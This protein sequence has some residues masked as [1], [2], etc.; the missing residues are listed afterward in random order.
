MI[1]DKKDFR[2]LEFYNEGKTVKQMCTIDPELKE[3][4]VY[5]RIE[6]MKKEGIILDDKED[7]KAAY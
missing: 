2:I 1:M 6:K 7:T 4:T 3:A 5:R